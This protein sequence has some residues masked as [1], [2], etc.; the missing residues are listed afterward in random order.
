[1]L[2]TTDSAPEV[3]AKSLQWLHL[4]QATAAIGAICSV[5]YAMRTPK[6]PEGEKQKNDAMF[7]HKSCGAFVAFTMPFRF[8]A[9]FAT[10]IPPSLPAP[11]IT[12][13][14]ASLVHASL[15][16]GLTMMSFSGV[17]MAVASG[18]G[19]PFFFTTIQFSQKPDPET[20]KS[21][22]KNH[23]QFGYYFQFLVPIHIGGSAFHW[24]QGQR[25][26]ARMNPFI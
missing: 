11:A 25:I 24:V 7:F 13:T 8:I 23:K 1:M 5:N 14:A 18:R 6:T 17:A 15:Y 2:S 19:L 3:Y 10:K 26:L 12:Q 21:I 9:R 20:A 16:I 4:L 22:Y